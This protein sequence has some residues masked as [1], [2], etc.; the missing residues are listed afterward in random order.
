MLL[1]KKVHSK[2]VQAKRPCGKSLLVQAEELWRTSRY[3]TTSENDH[4]INEYFRYDT[5]VHFHDC[6]ESMLVSWC[7]IWFVFMFQFVVITIVFFQ[8]Y[9]PLTFFI[10]RE[11]A[12]YAWQLRCH[13][14]G[15]SRVAG[16]LRISQSWAATIRV[17]IHQKSLVLLEIFV[18]SNHCSQSAPAQKRNFRGNEW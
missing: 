11:G 9:V 16:N 18:C 6:F 13:R 2:Q 8:S 4:Y 12:V 14:L 15:R 7:K 5:M 3:I 1:V 17:H 10:R